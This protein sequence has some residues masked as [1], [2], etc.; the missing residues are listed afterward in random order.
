LRLSWRHISAF[1]AEAAQL[2]AQAMDV[3]QVRIFANELV[4]V[5]QAGSPAATTRRREHASSIVKLFVSSPTIAPIGG[6]RWAAYNAITEW[7][8]HFSPVRGARNP[9]EASAAR[10][11]RAVAAASSAQS[12]KVEAFRIL[13]TL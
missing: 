2:Y 3:E 12:M 5:D 1:E 9:G 11:L 13:Q 7:V 10:A 8:D 6:T 4:K